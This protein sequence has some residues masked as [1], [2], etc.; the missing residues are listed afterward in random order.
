MNPS[1]SARQPLCDDC[2]MQEHQ[3]PP[4]RRRSGSELET[5]CRCGGLTR[6]GIYVEVDPQTV[7][8]PSLKDA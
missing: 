2:W 1:F 4:A 5:C 8:W 7:P 6:S 3:Q